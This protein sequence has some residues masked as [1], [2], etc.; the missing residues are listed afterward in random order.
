MQGSAELKSEKR[1]KE[2][3]GGRPRKPVAKSE[4]S[5]AIP[6]GGSRK[7]RHSRK[8]SPQNTVANENLAPNR[9][10]DQEAKQIKVDAKPVLPVRGNQVL[11]AFSLETSIWM[12]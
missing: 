8:H 7:G 5:Q 11:L 2:L 10:V 6:A 4:S 12:S 3:N 9:G 1:V